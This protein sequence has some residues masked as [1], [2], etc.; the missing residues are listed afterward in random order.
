MSIDQ[1]YEKLFNKKM[2]FLVK[3]KNN[4]LNGIYESKDDQELTELSFNYLLEDEVRFQNKYYKLAKPVQSFKFNEIL[5]MA[6]HTI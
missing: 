6:L 2:A 4:W 1:R 5:K 3:V